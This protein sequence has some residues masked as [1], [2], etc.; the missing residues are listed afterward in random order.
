MP[1]RSVVYRYTVTSNFRFIISATWSQRF[2]Q[3]GTTY[4]S[5]VESSIFIVVETAL[6]AGDMPRCYRKKN[7]KLKP[8][9]FEKVLREQ[10]K[11]GY[12]DI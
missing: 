3:Q 6:L 7:S 2:R 1:K 10:R 9:S 5:K 11:H 8:T 12:I 4:K